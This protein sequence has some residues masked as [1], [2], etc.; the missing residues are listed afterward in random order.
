MENFWLEL[1]IVIGKIFSFQTVVRADVLLS[2]A[3][4]MLDRLPISIP[5]LADLTLRP[6]CSFHLPALTE[7][8]ADFRMQV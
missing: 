2:A 6:M 3:A 8:D 1:N 5:Q 7:L 4:L